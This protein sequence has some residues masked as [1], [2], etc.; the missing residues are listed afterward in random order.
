MLCCR[1]ALEPEPYQPDLCLSAYLSAHV[2][3]T[4]DDRLSVNMKTV[5]HSSTVH[6]ELT[7]ARTGTAIGVTNWALSACSQTTHA[8]PYIEGIVAEALRHTPMFASPVALCRAHAQR[9]HAR[10]AG[11]AHRRF[12]GLEIVECPFANLPEA[13]SGRW[14]EGL[15]AAKMKNCRWLKPVL[16]ARLEFV[17]WTPDKHFRHSRFI[18][19]REEMI[20]LRL[21]ASVDRLVDLC[22][23]HSHPSF[24]REAGQST[25]RRLCARVNCAVSANHVSQPK[26]RAATN[27]A[28]KADM[29]FHRWS[30]YT[31]SEMVEQAHA[32]SFGVT[33]S[34]A[35]FSYV[36]DGYGLLR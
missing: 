11:V 12:R 24:R 36:R 9:L 8:D 32:R 10:S 23:A 30:T 7:Q 16:V 22:P 14:G 3:Y 26:T 34:F 2:I 29:R 15:T 4:S 21:G 13:R 33:S 1:D 18:G 25:T 28:R 27:S 19:L 31:N 20:A 5:H 35:R 17:E 6:V